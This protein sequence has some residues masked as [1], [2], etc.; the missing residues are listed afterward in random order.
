[1]KY[2]D[3]MAGATG[4]IIIQGVIMAIDKTA[5]RWMEEHGCGHLFRPVTLDLFR[6]ARGVPN[7]WYA[8]GYWYEKYTPPE[9][10]YAIN[11]VNAPV[12]VVP[13]PRTFEHIKGLKE[14]LADTHTVIFETTG[15]I[16]GDTTNHYCSP[17]RI[18]FE[19]N[20]HIYPK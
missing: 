5:F 16:F 14:A 6:G 15:E 2:L 10:Y 13:P 4:P 11:K 3:G 8:G 17:P 18:G 19:A 9:P 12:M 20:V 1:M 7:E